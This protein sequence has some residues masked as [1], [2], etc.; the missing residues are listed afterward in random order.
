MLITELAHPNSIKDMAHRLDTSGRA[1]SSTPCDAHESQSRPTGSMQCAVNQPCIQNL[2]L[3]QLCGTHSRTE[4]YMAPT[5]A[6]PGLHS[7]QCPVKG[8]Y[9]M[10]WVLE[11]LAVGSGTMCGTISD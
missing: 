4:P 3:V 11:Q 1:P 10:P 8:P 9:H 5:V 6:G 2:G 7:K